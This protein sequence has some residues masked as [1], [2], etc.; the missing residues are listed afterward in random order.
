MQRLIGYAAI[1]VVREHIL[2]FCY[3]SGGNG[4]SVFLET[5]NNL[6]G[7]YGHAAPNNF[8]MAQTYSQHPT[9]L[10]RLNGARMVLCSEVNQSDKFDEAK[11][12]HLTGGDAITARFMRQD[13][14]SFVP[15]HKLWLTGNF[16]PAV[17]AGGPGFWRRL[18]LI[19]FDNTV[20]SKREVTGLSGTL[21][22][23]H[24][25][26]VMAWI[27]AGAVTYLRHGLMEPDSVRI[28]TDEYAHEQ[29][30]VARFIEDCCYLSQ[31]DQVKTNTKHVRDAYVT[32]CRDQDLTPLTQHTFGRIL[33]TRYRVTLHRSHGLRLYLGLALVSTVTPP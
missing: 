8:L 4:K 10:A 26:A 3:G 32:Y 18:R 29:D 16:Q 7:D 24:G 14:F 22:G 6:L 15:S 2:P 27:V 11:I 33:R 31:S 30:S 12:K 28:A 20:D 17:E 1:G 23:Q 19:P 9:E 5:I 21:I 13:D 25:G